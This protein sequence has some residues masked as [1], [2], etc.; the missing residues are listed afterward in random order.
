VYPFL[1]Y[2]TVVW[3]QNAEKCAEGVSALQTWSRYIARL[4]STV[5]C[6]KRFPS[7]NIWTLFY[8]YIY[9]TTL[10]IKDKGSCITNDKLYAHNIK[11]WFEAHKLSLNFDKTH[12]IQ[13]T[14]RNSLQFDLV[15]SYANK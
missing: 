1:Y 3:G 6:R 11:P 4:K 5:S 14:T 8:L 10:F 2:G 7:L 15:I 13:L 9:E 12:Y